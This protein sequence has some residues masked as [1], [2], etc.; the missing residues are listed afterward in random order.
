MNN[1]LHD[2][3]R[4]LLAKVR[5]GD[6]A[7]PGDEEAIDLL[8]ARA[9]NY[10]VLTQS[11]KILDAGCGLGGTAQYVKNKTNAEVSGVDIDSVAIAHAKTTYAGIKFFT[12]DI[13]NSQQVFSDQQFQL[14]YMFNVLY[15][16]EDKVACLKNLAKNATPHAVLAIFDY[17]QTVSTDLSMTDLAGKTMYPLSL[18]DLKVIFD[19][20]GWELVEILDLRDNYLKWYEQFLQKIVAM[21]EKELLNEFSQATY[22]RVF[23]TFSNLLQNLRDNTLSGALIIGKKKLA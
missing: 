15:S 9:M 3:P 6:Y 21:K 16:I 7:H 18:S 22:Q 2:T 11:S 10:C 8:L 4:L 23:D 19:A 13:L 1:R 5:N 17:T 20:A 14:L 12:G